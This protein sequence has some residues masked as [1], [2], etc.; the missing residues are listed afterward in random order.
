MPV[1]LLLACAIHSWQ[2]HTSIRWPNTRISCNTK[3]VYVQRNCLHREGKLGLGTATIAGMKWAIDH[4]YALVLNLAGY[5]RN[6]IAQLLGW[7]EAKTR[8]LLYRGLEDL[9]KELTARGITL[10]QL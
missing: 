1:S 3:C 6:E 4:G 8:N 7:S 9:R 2:N 5:H 10:E